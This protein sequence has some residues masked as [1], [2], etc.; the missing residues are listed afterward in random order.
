MTQRPRLR[1]TTPGAER[2][3]AAA[4]GDEWILEL[5]DRS[6][7]GEA[8]WPWRGPTRALPHYSA[9]R[10]RAPRIPVLPRS[11]NRS[12][13]RI[14]YELQRGPI[15]PGQK[16]YVAC[17]DSLCLQPLHLVL[18]G[19][20][21]DV[22]LDAF[23][24]AR[25]EPQPRGDRRVRSARPRENR[26]ARGDQHPGRDGPGW[27]ELLELLGELEMGQAGIAEAIFER[28][29]LRVSWEGRELCG[30][31]CQAFGIERQ[32]SIDE[33][34]CERCFAADPGLSLRE[35]INWP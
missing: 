18:A 17:G 26:E 5:I 11:P 6:A 20:Q 14:V 35:A 22:R 2:T 24:G 28:D 12:A 32:R 30:G 19:N 13:R 4:S 33:R 3:A 7:G 1:G 10:G 25:G 8:C 34:F 16:V 31:C 29:G 9:R 15:P 27:R 23:R 21:L